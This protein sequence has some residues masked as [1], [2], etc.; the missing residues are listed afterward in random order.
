MEELKIGVDKKQADVIIQLA[1]RIVEERKKKTAENKA[2][3]SSSTVV[4]PYNYDYWERDQKD[5]LIYR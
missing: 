5:R 1:K 2:N 3:S 4:N